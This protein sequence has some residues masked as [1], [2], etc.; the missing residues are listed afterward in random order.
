MRA[1]RFGFVSVICVLCLWEYMW[2]WCR[3]SASHSCWERFLNSPPGPGIKLPNGETDAAEAWAAS[4][5]LLNRS[6]TSRFLGVT[7]STRVELEKGR[8]GAREVRQDVQ[9]DRK[10]RN[11]AGASIVGGLIGD[12]PLGL[13]GGVVEAGRKVDLGM[14]AR[15]RIL[16]EEEEIAA[17]SSFCSHRRRAYPLHHS[18]ADPSHQSLF[19]LIIS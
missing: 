13:V 2:R 7:A 1:S 17:C 14:V 12:V 8:V 16:S 3:V 6:P 19:S 18:L 15:A 11:A 9:A 4:V 5:T 10:A